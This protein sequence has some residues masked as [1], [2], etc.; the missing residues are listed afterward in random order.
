MATVA[1]Y[2][3]HV[4][5]AW[6]FYQDTPNIMF[7]IGRTT[8]WDNENNPPPPV[9]DK[10]ELDEVIGYKRFGTM[11]FVIP[12]SEGL[13]TV[14]GVRW[15]E[16]TVDPGIPDDTIYK[17]ALRENSRWV[18]VETILEPEDFTG[19]TYRQIGLYSRIE[20]DEGVSESEEIYIPAQI[21]DHGILEVYQNRRP[22]YRQ[23]DQRELVA[24][25]IE[26]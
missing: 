9:L 26:F 8:A 24:L 4:S 16:V 5:R 14:D 3:S 22:I 6:A 10:D 13:I 12:D 7:A 2:K 17:A 21:E 19:Q 25:I 11:K 23:I 20:L 18:Y 15:T 1:T